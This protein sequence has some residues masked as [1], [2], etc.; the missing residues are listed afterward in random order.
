MKEKLII[1]PAYTGCAT[2]DEAMR[3]QKARGF[4]WLEILL[5]DSI[6]WSK[7]LRSKTL[8]KSFQKACR[9]YGKF[10]SLIEAHFKRAPLKTSSGPID[11]REYRRFIEALT[12]VSD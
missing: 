12:F 6:D 11:D 9:W 7:K 10:K 8:K 1:I 5:N 2:L 4:L 3:D